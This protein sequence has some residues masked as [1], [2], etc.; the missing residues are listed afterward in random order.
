[1]D[2]ELNLNSEAVDQLAP[3]KPLVVEPTATLREVFALLRERNSG[4]CLICHSGELLG[5]FTERD[6]LRWMASRGKLDVPI[7]T[8]MTRQ[9]RVLHSGE[10]VGAAIRQMTEG[11]YR[12]LPI[13]DSQNRP[14]G[15][16]RVSHIVHYLVEH[17]PSAVYNLPPSPDPALLEREG[18]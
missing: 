8:V 6:A 10:T 3:H 5:I 1:M 11:G 2:V 16:V 13:V 14:V 12:R 7:E 4:S 18:P 17:F 15:M 9:P